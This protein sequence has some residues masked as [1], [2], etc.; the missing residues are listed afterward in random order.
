MSS[1]YIVKMKSLA[2]FNL[3]NISP[4]TDFCFKIETQLT[5]INKNILYITHMQDKILKL[6]KELTHDKDLQ[7]TVDNYFDDKDEEKA[8]QV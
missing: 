6:V 8:E 5:V 7:E 1:V 2:M 4:E 3:K